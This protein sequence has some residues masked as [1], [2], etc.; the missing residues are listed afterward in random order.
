MAGRYIKLVNGI[1]FNVDDIAMIAR[2]E[3][4]EYMIFI[5]GVTATAANAN[6]NDLDAIIALLGDNITIVEKPAE[7]P[8]KTKLEI[9]D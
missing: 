1:I 3:L 9:V 2:K 5:K 4:N 7:V 6:G 8:L